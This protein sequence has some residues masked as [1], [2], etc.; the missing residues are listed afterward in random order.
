[1]DVIEP[2]DIPIDWCS[3][4]VIVIKPNN[5]IRLC[6]DLTALNKAVLWEN[7]PMPVIEHTLALMSGAKYFMKLDYVSGF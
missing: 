6:V 7:H 3:G 1:M 5:D 2:V 4:L